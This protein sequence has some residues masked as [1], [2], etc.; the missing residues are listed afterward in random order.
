MT[1]GARRCSWTTRNAEATAQPRQA[2]EG[3]QVKS[4]FDFIGRT[5]ASRGA[6]SRSWTARKAE[7]PVYRRP[8][9]GEPAGRLFFNLSDGLTC[10]S[11]RWRL[12]LDTRK[13]EGAR[14]QFYQ[15]PL[16]K[17]LRH[18]PFTAVTRVRIP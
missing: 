3:R 6:R 15:G 8:A 7:A 17:R 16:V 10:D 9:Q 11:S 2:L 18:R 12:Q 4:F 5:E 14:I 13:A 1:R